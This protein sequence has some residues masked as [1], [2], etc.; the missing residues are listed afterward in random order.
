MRIQE[1]YTAISKCE[2]MCSAGKAATTYYIKAYQGDTLLH[3]NSLFS[4]TDIKD[5]NQDLEKT[6]L[7]RIYSEFEVTLR[8]YWEKGLGKRTKPCAQVLI[9]RIASRSYVQ[10]DVLSNVHSVRKYRNSLVHGGPVIPI[11]LGESRR[12][13]CQFLSNLPKNW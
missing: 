1:R 2:N 8:D 7:V 3:H 12:Y 6:Y 11:T 5:C 9:D 13:L 4:L 10:A